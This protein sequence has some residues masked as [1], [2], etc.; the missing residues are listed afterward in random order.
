[1]ESTNNSNN[2]NS[3]TP[4]TSKTK[5]VKV[6]KAKVEKA[7]VLKVV[8]KNTAI[9]KAVGKYLAGTSTGMGNICAGLD[10]DKIAFPSTEELANL[11]KRERKAPARL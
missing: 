1:M 2:S 5:P 8:N 6:E 10:W 3:V 7:K 4:K 11:G 9:K